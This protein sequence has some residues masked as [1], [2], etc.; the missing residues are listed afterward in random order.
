MTRSGDASHPTAPGAARRTLRRLL[1]AL[2]VVLLLSAPALA[3]SRAQVLAVA[4]QLRPPSCTPNFSA[5]DC[6]TAE[7]LQFRENI[8]RLLDQG[9][10]P[11]QIVQRYVRAYG[12]QVR[13]DP[14]SGG[15]DVLIWILPFAGVVLGAAIWWRYLRGAASRNAARA[16]AAPAP[17]GDPEPPVIDPELRDYL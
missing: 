10:T 17:P 7:A 4:G 16:P 14:P 2:G 8:A 12:P 15:V 6:P 11:R 5:A 9:L 1:A 13:F 3:A